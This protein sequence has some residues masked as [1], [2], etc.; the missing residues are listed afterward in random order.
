MASLK[1][2]IKKSANWL[3]QAFRALDKELDFSVKSVEH[4]ETVLTEQFENG[5]PR[6]DG[7]FASGLGGKLFAISS[8]IGEVIIRNTKAT[9]W[10]TDD[11]DPQGEINIKLVSANGTEMFP[12]HRVMKRLQNGEED[13]VYHYT[14]IA[15]KK[16]MNF[17]GEIP[18]GFIEVDE[19]GG[20]PW[21]KF[22]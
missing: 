4:I 9:K 14:A 19:N 16:Y 21:W 20:K 1:K 15:V 17:D 18:E 10:V 12:A 6:P 13:N 7:L 2:D 8:Y 3:V 5:Q 22:W 11:N